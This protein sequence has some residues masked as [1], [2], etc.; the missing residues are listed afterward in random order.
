VLGTP[1]GSNVT[2]F[3]K[4]LEPYPVDR[5]LARKLLAGKPP[6][7]I[8]TFTSDGRYIADRD[9]Y[10]AINAQLNSVGFKVTPQTMEWGRLIAMINQRNAGPFIIVGWDFGEGD[11]SKINSIFRPESPVSLVVDPEYNRLSDLAGAEMNETKRTAYWKQAQK[12]L[13]DKYYI[14]ATWQAASIFGVSKKLD[15]AADTGENFKLAA[16]KV[17]AK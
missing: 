11:A 9:I 3:D 4:T 10:Q 17:I 16:V 12:L 15:W 2:Q 1:M 6:I 8:S 7:E 5:A 13:H 14:A